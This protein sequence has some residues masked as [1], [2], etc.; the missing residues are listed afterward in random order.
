MVFRINTLALFSTVVIYS[1]NDVVAVLM[2]SKYASHLGKK[3]ANVGYFCTFFAVC[4]PLCKTLPSIF[5]C[6]GISELQFIGSYVI[7]G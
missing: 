7:I 3:N 5:S 6:R 1:M 2:T 4:K